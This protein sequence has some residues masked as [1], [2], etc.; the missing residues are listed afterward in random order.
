MSASSYLEILKEDVPCKFK[1][2]EGP[3]T[4]PSRQSCSDELK[5]SFEPTSSTASTESCHGNETESI[6][7]RDL[8]PGTRS[9]A[10]V[11]TLIYQ[12]EQGGQ[13]KNDLPYPCNR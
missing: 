8:G 7:E 3:Q 9:P 13:R 5:A 6:S 11:Q 10:A 1:P 12:F 4:K 2:D